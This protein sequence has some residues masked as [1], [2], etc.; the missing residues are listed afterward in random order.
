MIEAFDA[1]IA[2][3]DLNEHPF[4]RAWRE[5]TL[6]KEALARY[7]AEY[8]PFIQ[9]IALGWET[10]GD[11]EHAEAERGH[12]VLWGRFRDALGATGSASHEGTRRLA[13]QAERDFQSVPTALGAL[14]AFEAQQPKTSRSKLDGLE[15]HYGI[16]ADEYFRAHADDYGEKGRLAGKLA[17]LDDAARGLAA[18]ACERTCK[19]M[20]D[21][22]SAVMPAA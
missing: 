8:E 20:W 2:K 22:L 12:A 11:R 5:G 19:A 15:L 9:T 7:S 10:L 1:I 14:Y 17:Q 6:P 13:Q 18:D 21:A 3:H 4:Y 16:K